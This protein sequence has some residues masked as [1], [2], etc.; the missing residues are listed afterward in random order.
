[1]PSLF[2]F[3][4]FFI[5]K[6]KGGFRPI[7][8]MEPILMVFHKLLTNHMLKIVQLSDCQ[9]AFAKNALVRAKARVNQLLQ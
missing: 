6:K 3:E 5:P 7:S 2:R 1:M 4:A 9:F 8:V